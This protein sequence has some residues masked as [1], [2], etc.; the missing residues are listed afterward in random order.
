MVLVY[1]SMFGAPLGVAPGSL[2]PGFELSQDPSRIDEADAVV[3]HLPDLRKPWQ[4]RKRPG[5]LWVA[6]SMESE[7]HFPHLARLMPRFDLSM[8]FRRDA[9]V[10]VT[11]VPLDFLDL[12]TTSPRAADRLV[13]S[14]ISGHFGES[15]RSAYVDE[16]A[17]CLDVHRYGRL[18]GRRRIPNDRGRPSKLALFGQYKFVLGF[19]NAIEEDY[20]TEK[21]FEPLMSGSVP[22]YLG[23]PNVGE[24]APARDCYVDVSDFRGPEN[25]A[26]HLIA[27]GRDPEAYQEL[28]RWRNQPLRPE[29]LRLLA[30]AKESPFVRLCRRLAE[31]LKA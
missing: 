1:N 8:S 20:V 10:R 12:R 26:R 2:P 27:L 11:Y 19:E 17:R 22:V 24:L 7:A 28:H 9:D 6:W 4:I 30:L 5:Q 14:L 31:R 25:L 21:L 23:A 15:G 29:F 13:C 18:P 16:L 3:F